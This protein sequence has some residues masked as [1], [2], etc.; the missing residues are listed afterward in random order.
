[1]II[2]NICLLKSN[3]Q[4]NLQSAILYNKKLYAFQIDEERR[5]R[6]SRLYQQ[7]LCED[8]NSAHNL[9]LVLAASND[10]ALN[11]LDLDSDLGKVIGSLALDPEGK[12]RSLRTR[13]K[14]LCPNRE[15]ERGLFFRC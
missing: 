7:Q 4:L 3:S 15:S 1:M 2:C 8:P 5:R 12:P 13:V 10:L 6:L 11:D 14:S 9:A